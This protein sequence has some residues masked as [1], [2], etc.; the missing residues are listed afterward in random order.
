MN[1]LCS[2]VF[3]AIGLAM[4]AFAVSIVSS[5]IIGNVNKRQ[6]FRLSFHF[7]LFQALM[8]FIGWFIGKSLQSVVFG[9]G[10]KIAFII[11]VIIGIKAIIGGL[12][13]DKGNEEHN[14]D[15][16]KGFHLIALAVATSIDALAVGV[17]FGVMKTGIILPVII[18]GIITSVLSVVGIYIGKKVGK[19]FGSKMEIT[20]GMVLIAIGIK[21]LLVG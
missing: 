10:N 16:S 18:I 6:V 9:W 11:L 19:M 7:G 21:I 17:T 4:D 15:P 8:P 12:N 14:K 3:I 1:S 13:S 2:I 5:I 20:G